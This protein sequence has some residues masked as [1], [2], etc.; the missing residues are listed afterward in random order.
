MGGV[1]SAVGNVFSEVGHAVESIGQIAESTV[2]EVGHAAESVGREIGKIGEAAAKNPIGT[3]AKVAAV[4]SGQWWALPLVSAVDVVA[5][6]GD[7][8]IFHTVRMS[9]YC[10][11]GIGH[12]VRWDVVTLMSSDIVNHIDIRAVTSRMSVMVSEGWR[13]MG[14]RC[15]DG[16]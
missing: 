13:V 11:G 14:R 2:R 5:H 10:S 6:G 3:I 8:R 9:R 16:G 4:A 12:M 15:I 7:M 1:A